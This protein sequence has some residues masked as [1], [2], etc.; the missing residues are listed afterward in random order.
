M[1][2]LKRLWK[3]QGGS[4]TESV[5]GRHG[6]KRGMDMEADG[7][8]VSSLV[9]DADATISEILDEEDEAS[10]DASEDEY[11]YEQMAMFASGASPVATCWVPLV[12]IFVCMTYYDF[13]PVL[14]FTLA[15][16]ATAYIHVFLPEL[17][18]SRA[19]LSV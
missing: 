8:D 3:T 6:E 14:F 15:G 19:V 10:D 11:E 16:I 5:E 1:D 18:G 17:S 13:S 4:P 2:R 7:Q 9:Q 12:A